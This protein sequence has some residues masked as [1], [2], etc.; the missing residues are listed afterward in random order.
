MTKLRTYMYEL[1]AALSG[2]IAFV[3]QFCGAYVRLWCRKI[4]NIQT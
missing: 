1:V 3:V 4:K 2:S